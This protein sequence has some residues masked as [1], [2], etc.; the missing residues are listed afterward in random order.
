MKLR[1][2]LMALLALGV[3]QVVYAHHGTSITYDVTK[4]I[5]I[6]GTVTEF[7]W[8]FPHVQI[9]LDRQNDRG[10]IEKWGIEMAPTPTM[11]RNLNAGWGRST[12]KV[13]D[14]VTIVCNPHHV[15]GATA[16]LAK[17]ITANGKILPMNPDQVTRASTAN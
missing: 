3:N 7:F 10:D 6:S 14:E 4:T 2:A 1:F 15:A 17:Q 16:C 13:G 11:L 9:Y 8:G 12:L 5:T